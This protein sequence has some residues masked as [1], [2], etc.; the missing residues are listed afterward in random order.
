M[1]KSDNRTVKKKSDGKQAVTD[2]SADKKKA[3]LEALCEKYSV[4]HSC[5]TVS[6]ARS[7]AYEWRKTDTQFADDWDAAID[8]AVDALEA[9]LYERAKS[10]DT[11]AAIFLLKG[12]KP[13]KY[14]ERYESS[15][16]NFEYAAEDLDQLNDYELERLIAGDDP[17]SV[18]AAARKRIIKEKAKTG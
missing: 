18:F 8:N 9:S 11:T 4:Y 15:Q 14:R 1:P 17:R 7:T 12:A 13:E 6:I 5:K 10:S 2:K 16:S 3:F